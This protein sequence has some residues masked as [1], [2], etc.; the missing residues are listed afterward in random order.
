[1]I[2]RVVATG[3][4]GCDVCTAC[5]IVCDCKLSCSNTES[6]KLTEL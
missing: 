3:I 4:S 1:M 2:F 6:I 5:R